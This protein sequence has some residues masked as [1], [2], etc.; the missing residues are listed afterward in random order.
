MMNFKEN[1]VYISKIE[2]DKGIKKLFGRVFKN[3]ME[4]QTSIL[5]ENET[6]DNVEKKLI[7]SLEDWYVCGSKGLHNDCFSHKDIKLPVTKLFK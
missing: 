7:E 3:G 6:E 1:I 2:L 4:R 5:Y